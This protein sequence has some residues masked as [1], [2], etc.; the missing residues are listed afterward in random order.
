MNKLILST[1]SDIKYLNKIEPYLNSISINS[2]FDENVLVYL[3]DSE[4][5]LNI[6]KIN[7]AYL[8][9]TYIETPNINNC[10]QHGEFIKSKYFDKFNDTDVIFFTDGD[11]I[12]QRGLEKIE[13]IE[14][15]NLKNYDVYVGYNASPDDNLYDESKRLGI[16][17]NMFTEFNTDWEKI[18]A[19]NTGVLAMNK[20]TWEYLIEDYKILFPK[21]NKM[22][23]SYAKQQWLISFIIGTKKYNII[24]MPYHIHNHKHYESP[25][26]TYQD[27]NGDVFYNNKKVLFKHKW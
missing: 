11:I 6:E 13:D 5:K 17:E 2:N 3:S 1:G 26:G 18:K 4:I 27:L 22:S 16:K 25:E 19:Y 7:I 23:D 10:I 15:R 21:I 8:S 14:F 9:P 20:K 12:L 24:E